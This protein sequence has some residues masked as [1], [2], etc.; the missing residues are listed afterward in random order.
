MD[1]STGGFSSDFSISKIRLFF[2]FRRINCHDPSAIKMQIK[3]ITK[4]ENKNL[5]FKNQINFPKYRLQQI[6]TTIQHP[7][8]ANTKQRPQNQ[9]GALC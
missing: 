9:S 7:Q 3:K 8:S 1:N 6:K 2:Q 5:F 4:S